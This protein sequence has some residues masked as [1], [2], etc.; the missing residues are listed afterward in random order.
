MTGKSIFAIF[1]SL[2]IVAMVGGL[3]RPE[4]V[5]IA[6]TVF[7]CA[8]CA[9]SSIQEDFERQERLLTRYGEA[10]TD[11]KT[12]LAEQQNKLVLLTEEVSTVVNRANMAIKMRT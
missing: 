4:F 7:I 11:L 6:V 10:L 8:A 12:Q 5:F 9:A 2:G 1:V 3:Y